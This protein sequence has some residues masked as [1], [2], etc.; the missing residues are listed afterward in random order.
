MSLYVIFQ[1]Q[2]HTAIT[3]ILCCQSFDEVHWN[4]KDRSKSRFERKI[5]SSPS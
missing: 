5:L 2:I 4:K 3:Y 1:M